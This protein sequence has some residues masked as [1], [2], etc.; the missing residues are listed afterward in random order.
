MDTKD[1]KI[2]AN[3]QKKMGI[4]DSLSANFSKAKA[5]VFTNYQG[6]THKQIE[7]LKK[8][9]KP[10]EAEY[11][12]AK[13][14]LVTRSLDGNGI[15]LEGEHLLNGPTGTLFLYNDIVTPLRALAKMIKELNIPSVKFGIME[16]DF[17]TGE[18]V[19]KLSTLP[20]REVL[21]TQI[22]VA[23]KSPISGLHR[24]LNWNIQKL[25]MTLNAVANAKPALA[26]VTPAAP[27]L[28]EPTVEPVSEPVVQPQAQ[29][30]EPTAEP[31]EAQTD[32]KPVEETKT[33]EVKIEGG[34]N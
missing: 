14:S 22:A 12:V 7:E 6:L 10:L 32:E 3:R 21:L 8:A 13:N 31:V 25:V 29:G 34:E 15:K 24:A 23:L 27:V 4:V 17:I 5:V 9:I 16:K 1:T 26:T 33:E 18:Q 28:S 20:S 2:T 11:V 19:M 30:T